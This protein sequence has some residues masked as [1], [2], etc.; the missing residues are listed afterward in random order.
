[1]IRFW[2]ASSR[3]VDVQHAHHRVADHQRRAEDRVD[4]LHDDRLGGAQLLVRLDVDER[5][6]L[7]LLDDVGQQRVADG[8]L[9]G[10][11]LVLSAHLDLGERTAVVPEERDRGAGGMEV[12]HHPVDDE[13]E[14]LVHRTVFDQLPR[15]QCEGLQARHVLR[16]RLVGDVV[17]RDGN[18]GADG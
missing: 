14:Q 17:D 9:A 6:R 12:L 1:M 2:I 4:A 16:F 8:Q 10:V 3:I 5:Q 11:R 18:G 7:L 15:Q 13:A